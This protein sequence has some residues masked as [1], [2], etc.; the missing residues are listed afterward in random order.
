MYDKSLEVGRVVVDP[1]WIRRGQVK[2]LVRIQVFSFVSFYP[3]V[4]PSVP[5]GNNMLALRMCEIGD[6]TDQY[7]PFAL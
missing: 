1:S 6:R 2:S 3:L 4:E 5:S 7:A